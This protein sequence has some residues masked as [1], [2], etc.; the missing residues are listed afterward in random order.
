MKKWHITPLVWL[1]SLPVF[2]QLNLKA[3]YCLSLLDAPS[4][5]AIVQLHNASLGSAYSNPFKPLEILHGL[6]LGLEYRWEGFALE[7]GWRTKRNREEATGSHSQ[8]SFYNNLNFSLSSF[9]GG[10]IQYYGPV[11]IS[12]SIDYNYTRTKID[13][14]DPSI[15]TT[16]KDKG[17]GSNFS[18]GYVLGG[19]GPVSLVI[20]P[21]VQV[22]WMDYDL[23]HF[24]NIL[25]DAPDPPA[26]EDYFNYG[27]TV[28]FL[29]GPN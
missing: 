27:L 5:D 20:A 13:F 3:G 22:H 9:Y 19:N 17:W 4:H 21:Y 11:R 23:T 2:V 6:D 25:S 18:L 8:V 29:N 15:L 26:R 10:I 12:A 14:E 28:Y 7:A 1:L 24:Q 16:L